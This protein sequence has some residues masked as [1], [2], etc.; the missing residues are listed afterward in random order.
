MTTFTGTNKDNTLTGSAGADDFF[1]LDGNDTVNAGAGNDT[2]YGGSGNDSLSGEGDNDS[3]FGE[4]GADSLYGGTGNDLLDG[5]ASNDQLFGGDG[6]DTL[7]GGAGSDTLSGGIGTDTANYSA[8]T[9]PVNVNLYSGTATGG[10]A[11]GDTL[12]SIEN[13]VGSAGADT[14]TGSDSLTSQSGDNEILGGNGNDII[15][16]RSGNDTLAGEAGNDSVLG[17]HGNDSIT[18]GDGLDTLRGGQGND[19]IDGGNDADLIRGDSDV[20]ST[21]SYRLYDRDFSTANGQA[22]TIESGTLRAESTV[23]DFT[24]ITGIVQNARGSTADP[25]DFGIILTS[26]YTAGTATSYRFAT[27][28]DDG[29]TVRILDANG[30]PLTFTNQTGSSLTYM[31]NDFHQASTTRYGDVTLVPGQTYTIEIRMWENTGQ[32]VLGAHHFAGDLCQVHQGRVAHGVA[33]AVVDVLEVVDVQQRQAQGVAQAAG[34]GH[35]ALHG[36]VQ[37]FAVEG[38]GQRVVPCLGAGAVQLLLQLGYFGVLGVGAL[39]QFLQLGVG[40]F[41]VQG[42]GAGGGH[43]L[44]EHRSDFLEVVGLAD[45]VGAARQE[46]FWG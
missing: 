17:G 10:D 12:T 40:E 37:P 31:D 18:G 7:T 29:S 33:Q 8:S 26:T 20:A 32:Q 13:L 43:D 21:W 2:I 23:T 9:S 38:A 5:G 39:A 35:L 4:D 42:H 45:Q 1:A 3:I 11:A 27:T 22:F 30:N 44:F 15:D 24:G 41:G 46:A 6:N 19:T 36:F 28:S 34:A 25:E 14:L 16:G